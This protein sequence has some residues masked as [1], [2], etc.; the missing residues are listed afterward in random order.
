[1][2]EEKGGCPQPVKSPKPQ[3]LTHQVKDRNRI[4]LRKRKLLPWENRKKKKKK[5]RLENFSSQC[6]YMWQTEH[7]APQRNKNSRVRILREHRVSCRISS[8]CER[9]KQQNSSGLKKTDVSF[10]LTEMKSGVRN[11]E[12]VWQLPG[13]KVPAAYPSVPVLCTGLPPD[14]LRGPLN[15]QPLHS[16]S[17]QKKSKKEQRSRY[18]PFQTPADIPLA[19]TNLLC[20][21]N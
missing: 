6:V 15:L 8:T 21:H 20:G 5:K 1:M 10:S 19:T 7:K 11:Q 9:K 14:G 4:L 13:I 16:Y 2:T 3:I 18:P 12:L 17:H